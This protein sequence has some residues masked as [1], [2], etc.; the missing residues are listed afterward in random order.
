MSHDNPPHSPADAD[1][2]PDDTTNED[3]PHIQHIIDNITADAWDDWYIDHLRQQTVEEGKPWY[4]SSA[5]V[6]DPEKHTPSRILKCHRKIY[7]QAHNAPEEDDEPRGIFRF[8]EYVER[9]IALPWLITVVRRISAELDRDMYVGNDLDVYYDVDA[10][11]GTNIWISGDTDP[12]VLDDTG[13]PVV[14]TEVKTFSD[15][16]W[17][18]KETHIAQIYAYIYGMRERYD[19]DVDRGLLLYFHRKKLYLKVFEIEF[20]DARWDEI[21]TWCSEQTEYREK[22][23]LPPADPM[24]DRECKYCSFRHRCGQSNMPH[25]DVDVDGFIPRH[26]YPEQRVR[27]HLSARDDAVLTPTI[28]DMYPDLAEQHP[29]APWI[30]PACDAEYA[31]EQLTSKPSPENPPMCPDC[32]SEGR[33]VEMHGPPPD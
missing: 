16:H 4:L 11:D 33:Q 6:P 7:Y 17:I 1:T 14:P 8:G 25:R 27:E 18:P 28:A 9:E 32:A 13:D 30:C 3:Q 29:V 21:L 5:P 12:V 31:W 22:E 15:P 26:G 24:H 2:D 23:N 19:A 20:D 10:P